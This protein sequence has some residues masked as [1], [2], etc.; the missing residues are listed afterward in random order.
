MVNLVVQLQSESS[1]F[2]CLPSVDLP[3]EVSTVV[4]G[5]IA[6]FTTVLR[7]LFRR[8]R[9]WWDD[10]CASFSMLFFILHVASVFIDIYGPSMHHVSIRL[11]VQLSNYLI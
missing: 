6:L 2:S 1:V 5:V 10:A 3:S 9:F 11:C 4:G 7:L 8:N